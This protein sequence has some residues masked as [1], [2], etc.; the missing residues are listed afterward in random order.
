MA[1]DMLLSDSEVYEN[2]TNIQAPPTEAELRKIRR[3]IDISQVVVWDKV[4]D[5]L[6]QF[7]ALVDDP[8]IHSVVIHYSPEVARRLLEVTNTNNRPKGTKHAENLAREI[9]DG[10]YGLTGDTVKFADSGR[11]LDGQHRF[12]GC[13]KQKKAIVSHT[14]FGLSEEIFDL[15]DQGKKRTAADVLSMCGVKNATII[16]GAVSWV[17]NIRD[18]RRNDAGLGGRVTVRD[19]KE[20]A[21]GPMAGLQDWTNEAHMLNAAFKQPPSLM[22]AILFEI[23]RHSRLVATDFAQSWLSGARVGRNKT[24]DMLQ[25]RLDVVRQDSGGVLNRFV[26]AALVIQAFNNWHADYAASPRALSWNRKNEFPVLQF[27][28]EKFREGRKL[29]IKTEDTLN[30]CQNRVLLALDELKDADGNVIATHAKLARQSNVNERQIGYILGTLQREGF[31]HLSKKGTLNGS[32]GASPDIW[33]LR[34]SGTTR[35]NTYILETA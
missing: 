24:F 2:L 8:P 35:L 6:Q 11:M 23:S 31:T 14:V 3:Q 28:A 30:A 7:A 26:N 4:N 25:H 34:P 12:E 16:A 20:L 10:D 17:K 15:I 33:R 29:G 9:A 13:A 1:Q 21:I 27:D 18:R 5:A 19:I 22:C 32:K